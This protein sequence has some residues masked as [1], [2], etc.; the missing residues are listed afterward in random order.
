[1]N[2]EINIKDIDFILKTENNEIKKIKDIKDDNIIFDNEINKEE[3]ND[4]E[5]TEY[6]EFDII[7]EN[8]NDNLNQN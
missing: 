3:I 8:P 5:L 7:L 1:M 4:D 2:K 6:N